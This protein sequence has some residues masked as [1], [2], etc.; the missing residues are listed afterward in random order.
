MNIILSK[1]TR[2][3]TMKETIKAKQKRTQLRNKKHLETILNKL[4]SV[5]DDIKKFLLYKEGRPVTYKALGIALRE[6]AVYS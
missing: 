3:K 2:T 1:H 4:E 6:K 5:L